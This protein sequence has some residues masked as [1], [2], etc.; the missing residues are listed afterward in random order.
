MGSRGQLL[1][2]C[3]APRTVNRYRYTDIHGGTQRREDI[4]SRG[5]IF[6]CCCCCFFLIILL[7]SFFFFFFFLYSS[8][9]YCNAVWGLSAP[10]IIRGSVNGERAI[11]SLFLSLSITW[12]D[13]LGRLH[14]WW[15]PIVYTGLRRY[16]WFRQLQR[17]L[18][19]ESRHRIRH[20]AS[21]VSKPQK[22]VYHQGRRNATDRGKICCFE[23][24]VLC[25]LFSGVRMGPRNNAKGT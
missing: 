2:L 10:I 14:R 11:F 17:T 18:P 7:V 12:G 3:A 9:W 5:T 24:S 19:S 23:F 13:F 15:R 20:R 25:S 22:A 21:G 8:F 16:T 1:K 6:T 4:H